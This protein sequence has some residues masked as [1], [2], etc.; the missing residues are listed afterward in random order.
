MLDKSI[1]GFY[2]QH[3]NPVKRRSGA[4]K[5]PPH[6]EGGHQRGGGNRNLV[7]TYAWR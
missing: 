5:R 7:R 4:V 1:T 2:P 6:Q 3:V